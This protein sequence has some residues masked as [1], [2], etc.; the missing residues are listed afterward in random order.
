MIRMRAFELYQMRGHEPGHEREDW[1][2]AEREVLDFLIHEENRRNADARAGVVGQAGQ[3]EGVL[4]VWS[5][6]EPASAELAP[7][8][9]SEPEPALKAPEKKRKS[10]AKASATRKAKSKDETGEG[11][12]KTSTK[13]RA[14]KTDAKKD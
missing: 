10:G 3:P 1:F 6:A 12:K 4:G 13:S 8:I 14:K 9:G 11:S 7:T 2:K 5:A